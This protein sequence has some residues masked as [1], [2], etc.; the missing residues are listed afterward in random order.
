MAG[1]TW[2]VVAFAVEA[3]AMQAAAKNYG[4]RYNGLGALEGTWKMTNQAPMAYRVLMAWL[5]AWLPNGLQLHVYQAV[6]TLALACGLWL[7]GLG[8]G[9]AAALGLA[10]LLAI[11]FRYDYW[12]W[13]I[14]ILCIGLALTGDF[15][16]ALVG[17]IVWGLSRET[18]PL[19]GVVFW[20][21]EPDL[22]GAGAVAVT[23]GL[24]M[25]AVRMAVGEKELYCERVMVRRNLANL[26][27]AWDN[28]QNPMAAWGHPGRAV[29]ITLLG[30]GAAVSQALGW[31]VIILSLAAGWI[32][33][34]AD[35][36][37]VFTPAL[38]FISGWLWGG[39]A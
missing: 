26:K 25:L 23:A 34:L 8:L 29:F 11:T 14:E 32:F 3:G 24:V 19:A 27:H 9:T 5:V 35:E 30:L 38:V 39:Y 16:L 18:A 28:R 20:L 4:S 2:L 33:A 36:V 17:A 10:G 12:D 37:R 7:V 6:K 15:R 21:R 1:L 22:H 31:P 13:E